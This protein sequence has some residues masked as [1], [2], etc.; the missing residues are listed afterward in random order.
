MDESHTSQNIYEKLL[1]VLNDWNILEK[2][3]LCL[4]DS[5][6]NMVGAFD[7]EESVLNSA[8]CVNHT[9]QLSIKDEIFTLPS[10]KKLIDKCKSL[11]A[12]A[13]HSNNFYRDFRKAQVEQMH[14]EPNEVKNLVQDVD[15][16]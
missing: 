16:R 1:N 13:N 11:V 5:A 14:R 7:L 4:R 9:L 12:H 15:T 3:G 8:G 10:V 6:S 2:V